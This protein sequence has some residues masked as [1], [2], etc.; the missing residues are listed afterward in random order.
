[1]IFSMPAGAL[2]QRLLTAVRALA[3]Q[4]FD[5]LHRYALAVHTDEPRPHVHMVIRAP[6]DN[7]LVRLNI[8]KPQL[9]KWREGFAHHL[10]AQGVA[11]QAMWWREPQ[12]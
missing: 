3:R 11:A 1:M 8:R 5:G 4:E 10:L 9:R 7:E 12:Q 2:P 6:R